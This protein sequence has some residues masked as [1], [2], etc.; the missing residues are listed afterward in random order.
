MKNDLKKVGD[1]LALQVEQLPEKLANRETVRNFATSFRQTYKIPFDNINI[2]ENF[3]VRITN[4]DIEE[5]ASGILGSNF[6]TEPIE[7]D[8]DSKGYFYI[9]EGHRRYYAMKLLRERGHPIKEMEAFVNNGKTKE[10]DRIFKLF[11]SQNNKKLEPLEVALV[12]KRL[13]G[14]GYKSG[15][16]ANKIGKSL[17]YVKDH[18]A[19]AK[20]DIEIQHAL[21]EG[22]ITLTSITTA[23]KKKVSSRDLK[24]IIEEK[25]KKGKAVKNKDISIAAAKKKPAEFGVTYDM[26]D[27]VLLAWSGWAVHEK[28]E[29]TELKK[30]LKALWK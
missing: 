25:K 16:I 6:V 5:L 1:L 27:K 3:N 19:L 2:R 7:G 9:V 26:V 18:L 17:D 10:D 30:E 28:K 8:M 23:R 15:E 29:L 14:L 12:L 22:L 4:M 11:S 21:E 20:E 13:E 24:E